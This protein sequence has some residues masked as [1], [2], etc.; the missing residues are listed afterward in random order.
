MAGIYDHGDWSIFVGQVDGESVPGNSQY[1]SQEAVESPLL[2]TI[3]RS[4]SRA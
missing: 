2:R 4:A 1:Q 3:E